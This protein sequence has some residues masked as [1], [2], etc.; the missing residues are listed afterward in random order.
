MAA[1]FPNLIVHLD[2]IRAAGSQAIFVW[3]LEGTHAGTDNRVKVRGW[4]EWTLSENCLVESSLGR[5]DATEYDR[6][7][8]EGI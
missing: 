5:F 7:I 4:E 2:D 3:T 6:Q 8:A 1:G